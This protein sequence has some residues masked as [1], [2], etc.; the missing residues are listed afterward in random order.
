MLAVV[1]WG[2]LHWRG[3]IVTRRMSGQDVRVVPSSP[4]AASAATSRLGP[5]LATQDAL[6]VW[7][8]PSCRIWGRIRRGEE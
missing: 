8:Q 1:S 7:A 5:S 6:E 3:T 4:R 2:R